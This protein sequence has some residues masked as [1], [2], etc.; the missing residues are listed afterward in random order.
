MA[1]VRVIDLQNTK[2]SIV[3]PKVLKK[4]TFGTTIDTFYVFPIVFP[5]F[6]IIFAEDLLHSAI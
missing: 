1:A 3:V 2:S 4:A 5:L 6:Y